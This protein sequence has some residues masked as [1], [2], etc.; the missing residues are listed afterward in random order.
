MYFYTNFSLQ[1]FVFFF[2]FCFTNNSIYAIFIRIHVEGIVRVNRGCTTK[3]SQHFCS[4]T[5]FILKKGKN[6]ERD[7][8]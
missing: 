1:Y 2:L 4:T 5:N 8:M 6:I 3:Y 7:V